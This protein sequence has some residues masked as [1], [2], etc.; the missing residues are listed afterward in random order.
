MCE[1]E[2][3]RE[4]ETQL[5]REQVNQRFQCY[6]RKGQLRIASLLESFPVM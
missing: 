3:E 5:E 6:L 1:T 4:R 2:R